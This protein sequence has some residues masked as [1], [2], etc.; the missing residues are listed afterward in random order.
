MHLYLVTPSDAP[1]LS[2]FAETFTQASE[3]FTVWWL[4]HRKGTL[5]SFEIKQ[6]NPSWQGLDTKLLAEALSL[7]LAGIGNFDPIQGWTISPIGHDEE[8]I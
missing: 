4:T 1:E 8:Q 3:L 5:P 6:R 7:D 2:V